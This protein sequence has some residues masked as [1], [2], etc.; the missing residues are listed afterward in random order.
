M[1]LFIIKTCKKFVKIPRGGVSRRLLLYLPVKLKRGYNGIP[2]DFP[3]KCVTNL[4]K[5]INWYL[6]SSQIT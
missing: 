3:K 5:Y 1:Y 6:K 4:F 2:E